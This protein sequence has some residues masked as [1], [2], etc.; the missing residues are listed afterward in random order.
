MYLLGVSSWERVSGFKLCCWMLVS[1]GVSKGF[2]SDMFVSLTESDFTR[3]SICRMSCL[4]AQK[5]GHII[6]TEEYVKQ[7]VVVCNYS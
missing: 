3:T 2:D 1:V 4:L 7:C 5:T 6:E